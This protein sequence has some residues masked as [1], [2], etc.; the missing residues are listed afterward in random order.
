[1]RLFT[2]KKSYK[3]VIEEIAIDAFHISLLEVPGLNSPPEELGSYMLNTLEGS[4][5]IFFLVERSFLAIPNKNHREKAK[6]YFATILFRDMEDDYSSREMNSFVIPLFELRLNDYH[7]IL[8]GT[9]D[10]NSKILKVGDQM[11]D[12]FIEE[13]VSAE[14]KLQATLYLYNNLSIKPAKI[15][16]SLSDENGIKW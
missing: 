11:I 6:E 4:A 9:G 7:S 15:L 10:V 8:D 5:A 14:N 13:E 1:M 2:W 12:N 16:K 3:K